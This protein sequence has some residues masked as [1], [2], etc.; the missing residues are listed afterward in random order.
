[1]EEAVSAIVEVVTE[2]GTVEVVTE[3]GTVLTEG[4]ERRNMEE[5]RFDIVG[6][7]RR[8]SAT[9]G[10]LLPEVCLEGDSLALESCSAID[11]KKDSSA[12]GLVE[13]VEKASLDERKLRRAS[14]FFASVVGAVMTW[15]N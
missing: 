6:R 4:E 14:S 13:S 5:R 12:V 15:T 11:V 8:S 1:M 7:L 2:N 9:I 10:L 3:K